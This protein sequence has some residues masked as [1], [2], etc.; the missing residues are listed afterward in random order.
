MTDEAFF[1]NRSFS[2]ESFLL[3]PL[4]TEQPVR[5]TTLWHRWKMLYNNHNFEQFP[6]LIK[7]FFTRR[8][9]ASVHKFEIAKYHEPSAMTSL[10]VFAK[11][12][13]SS[14]KSFL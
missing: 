13:K 6:N 14:N 4:K 8:T 11:S 10:V 9:F 5:I 2:P 7:L 3:L 1:R 12:L